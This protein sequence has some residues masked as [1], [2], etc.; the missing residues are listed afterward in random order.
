M[1]NFYD[2]HHHHHDESRTLEAC[3]KLPVWVIF[4]NISKIK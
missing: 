4:I 2:L 3:K 1:I